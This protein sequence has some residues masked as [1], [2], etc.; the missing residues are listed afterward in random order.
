M[1]DV[2]VLKWFKR[3]MTKSYKELW[4]MVYGF[5]EYKSG[6]L[7]RYERYKTRVES[8]DTTVDVLRKRIAKLEKELERKRGEEDGKGS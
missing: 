1:G 4:L 5:D 3:W 8:L 2:F 6:L 7:Y